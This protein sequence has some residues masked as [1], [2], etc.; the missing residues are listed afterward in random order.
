MYPLG[1]ELEFA[2]DRA[3]DARAAAEE[4]RLVR[5]AVGPRPTLRARVARRLFQAAI[6]LEREE[7]WRVVWDKL[8]APKHP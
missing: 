1:W 8:E 7:A 3:A 6:A 5:M 4:R 2:R